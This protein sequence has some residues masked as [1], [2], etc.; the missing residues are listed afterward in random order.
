M[1]VLKVLFGILLLILF[2]VGVGIFAIPKWVASTQGKDFVLKK[3]N[4]TTPGKLDIDI[5]SLGWTSGLTIERLSYTD[6]HGRPMAHV[7]E[8]FLAKSLFKL[9]W[10]YQDLG[11]LLIKKPTIYVYSAASDTGVPEG[12]G[13]K[14]ETSQDST[15]TRSAGVSD[16][17]GGLPD[18]K[19]HL[20]VEDGT[21][22][23]GTTQEDAKTVA[24]NINLKVT[25]DNWKSPVG[26]DLSLS[27]GGANGRLRCSGKATIGDLKNLN[28]NAIATTTEIDIEA[29]QLEETLNLASALGNVPR[30][31]GMVNGT[32]RVDG[33]LEQGL[34]VLTS[35]EITDLSLSGGPLNEDHLTIP[36]TTLRVQGRFEEDSLSLSN[37]TLR[38]NLATIEASGRVSTSTDGEITIAGFIDLAE[39][40]GQFPTTLGLKESLTLDEG[41][42]NITATLGSQDARYTMDSTLAI[43]TLVGSSD[44][45]PLRWDQ[46]TTL[47]TRGSWGSA[48][49]E[50]EQLELASPMINVSGK[51]TMNDFFIEVHTDLEP[52]LLEAAKFVDLEAWTATGRLTGHA[53][54]STDI[55]EKSDGT[56]DRPSDLKLMFDAKGESLALSMDGQQLIPEGPLSI[57]GSANARLDVNQHW[58]EVVAPSLAYTTW[59]GDGKVDVTRVGMSGGETLPTLQGLRGSGDLNLDHLQTLL[60]GLKVLPE[61]LTIGGNATWSADASTEAGTV[62]VANLDIALSKFR[63]QQDDKSIP[64]QDIRLTTSASVSTQSRSLEIRSLQLL[65][66]AGPIDVTNV[67]MGDWT[68]V[69]ESTSARIK[70][71]L[72]AHRL[73]ASL[74]SFASFPDGKAIAA[75][76]DV[77]ASVKASEN[78]GQTIELDGTLADFKLTEG[79]KE[80]IHE[81]DNITIEARLT[82]QEANLFVNTLTLESS[83]MQFHVE[84]AALKEEVGQHQLLAKGDMGFDLDIMATYMNSLAGLDLVMHGKER[85]PFELTSNWQS[86]EENGF[87]KHALMD[88]GFHADT[89]RGFGLEMADLSVPITMADG[90]VTIDMTGLVN[91]GQLTVHPTIDFNQGAGLVTFLENS[92]L[93]TSVELTEEVANELLAKF[94]PLFKGTTGIRG[95]MD[96]HM[97]QFYWPLDAEL[98]GERQ[99][100][101]ELAFTN[102]NVQ[103]SGILLK[104]LEVMK[105]KEQEVK[106]GEKDVTFECRDQR[107]HCSPLRFKVDTHDVSIEGSIGFDQTLDYYA[108]IP[109]T[110]ALA[111][112]IGVGG[113]DYTNYLAGVTIHVPIRGT[114]S[115]PDISSRV[116]SDAL[117]DL[118][119]QA[120]KKAATSAVKDLLNE[121]IGEEA[122][123]LLEGLFGK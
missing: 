59:L 99:F 73:L 11:E 78:Q 85:R 101:G 56:L 40:V 103:A 35:V 96:L 123:K 47:K 112:S 53:R 118:A 98:E 7:E 115:H 52:A 89:L 68:H 80:L 119:A 62:E 64:A 6:E 33:S 24:Q 13:G 32:V 37:I 17:S 46:P 23:T 111:H 36:S 10:N 20:M 3:V 67:V 38:S 30:G 108:N 54:L 69:L 18:I 74:G 106:I 88:L 41:D 44:G 117:S 71:E 121:N 21:V 42:L 94:H 58:T 113:R 25:L 43:D 93:L 63:L 34:D 16:T 105:V 83:P 27:A 92:N 84:E 1:R 51:G 15:S 79:E 57:E 4:D 45:K 65:T 19:L 26:Y 104:L 114:P 76:I 109:V 100:R 2:L 81:K 8:V 60:Q 12:D 49:K 22:Y 66:E 75:Q 110:E 70:A 107:I 87:M 97:E 5:V 102:V 31:S 77:Q 91:G 50:L 90:F 86:G 122:G 9:I 61:G 120:A 82:R 55:R 28:P 48:R 14:D 72:D 29:W 95:E 39:I 116:I